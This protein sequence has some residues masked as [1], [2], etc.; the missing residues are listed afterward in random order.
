M[1]SENESGVEE[2]VERM[3]LN[4]KPKKYMLVTLLKFSIVFWGT[5][6]KMEFGFRQPL[7]LPITALFLEQLKCHNFLKLFWKIT[8]ENKFSL[9]PFATNLILENRKH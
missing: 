2:T 8:Q 1:T 3:N 9:N 7:L 4:T 5:A 6:N